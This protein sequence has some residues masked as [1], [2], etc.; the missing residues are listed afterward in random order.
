MALHE[1]EKK[2]AIVIFILLSISCTKQ[3]KPFSSEIKDA[4]HSLG[5]KSSISYDIDY[6]IKFFDHDNLSQAN[7][8]VSLI[9]NSSDSIFGGSFYYTIKDSSSHYSKYYDLYTLYYINHKLGEVISYEPR[10]GRLGLLQEQW[11][12]RYSILILKTLKTS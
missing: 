2:I 12:E 7:T 5:N 1:E 8:R 11:T 6:A 3:Y 4:V 10:I 9:R